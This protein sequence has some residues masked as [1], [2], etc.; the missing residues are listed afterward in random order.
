VWFFSKAVRVVC[1]FG[2]DDVTGQHVTRP[3]SPRRLA[4]AIR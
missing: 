1:L 4:V 2:G 3:V